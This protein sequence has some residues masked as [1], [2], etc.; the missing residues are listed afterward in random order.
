MLVN[1]K[2]ESRK[3]I[4]D[5]VLN[6]AKA[7]VKKEI[8][9]CSLAIDDGRIVKIGKETKMPQADSKTDLHDLLVLPGL[10]DSHVH[11]RDEGKAY[12]EDF[13]SGTSAAAAGGFTTVLDMPNNDPVTMSV[14]TLRNRMEK[15][16]RAVLVNV[17]FFSEFPK[18]L[19][20]MDGIVR[21]GAVAFKLFMVDQIGGLNLNDDEALLQAFKIAGQLNAPVAAH[22]EDGKLLKE[23]IDK[24]K[25]SN[26]NDIGAYLKAHS[27]E[28]EEKA[29]RRLINVASKAENHLHICHLTTE[30]R[31]LTIVDGKNSGIQVTCET[32]PHNLFLS[33][34]DL[35]RIG[36]LALTMPPVRDKRDIEALWQGIQKGWI[37]TLGSDHAPHALGEKEAETIWNVKVGISGLETTLPLLLTA[38]HQRKLAIDDIVRLMAEKPAEIFNLKG[39]GLVKEG[40]AA[41]LSIIDLK[42]EFKIDA[43]KFYSKAKYSPFDG[44]SVKG[45]A[46]KVFVNGQLIMDEGEIVAKAGSGLIING[47]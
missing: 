3:L 18:N 17:G 7:Y 33:A 34:N 15:A 21:Q 24:F 22:A 31:L 20:E 29:V 12:K 8:V 39:R 23:A 26:R 35:K 44:W 19:E 43:S 37:D 40:N 38:L 41:D 9:D 42:R 30:K 13:F 47:D 32:T 28:V 2:K 25:R 4:V 11:L 5:L 27:E 1:S 10:I 14:E 46:V 16:E 36:T 45:K 6:R